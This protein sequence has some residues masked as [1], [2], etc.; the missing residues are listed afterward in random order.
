M[1]GNLA[2]SSAQI[3]GGSL[4]SERL[5]VA[6]RFI[7][8]FPV[9]KNS[10]ILYH[11][12]L[13]W[14]REK[15]EEE[16]NLMS[17]KH[18]ETVQKQFTKTIEEFSKFAVRDT[19][20]VLAERVEF[21]KP[22]PTDLV[23]DLA[24]GPGPFV[25]AVAPRVRF[26]QGVDLTFEMI[27]RART[28][29]AERQVTNAAFACGD[30]E[31]L[32]FPDATYDLVACHCAFHHMPKPGAVLKEMVRV[33][34][35]D[36]RL[37]LVDPLGPESEAKFE[38]HNRIE[39]VRDPSHALTL[40]L[41]TYLTMFD[42]QSLEIARQALRRRPRSF[43]HWMLRAGVKP[44]QKRYRETRRLLEDSI[45]GDRAGF[46]AQIQG[47]DILIVHNEGAFVLVRKQEEPTQAA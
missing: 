30:A 36:G 18:K 26:A 45:A 22:Q 14:Y 25:L 38:L 9:P 35:P 4:H 7:P 40:R 32:P 20:E 29:Q 6:D 47:D 5:G 19:P 41:T 46:S 10:G 8:I 27:R 31:H 37:L 43:N 17:K 1:L 23:L 11:S 15:R 16:Q 33:M 28:F 2:R 39:K 44:G 3:V 42:E 24:C 13:Q 34:K 12:G 21:I